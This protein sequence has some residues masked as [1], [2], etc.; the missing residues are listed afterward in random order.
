MTSEKLEEVLSNYIIKPSYY[1]GDYIPYMQTIFYNLIKDD[2]PPTQENY[3]SE[4]FKQVPKKSS[5]GTRLRSSYML[6]IRKYHL[7]YLLREEFENVIDEMDI[8]SGVDFI[9]NKEYSIHSFLKTDSLGFRKYKNAQ[10]FFLGKHI[11]L[12]L[13]LKKAKRVGNFLLYSK[14]DVIMLKQRLGKVGGMADA[15]E[16]FAS[17]NLAPST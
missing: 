9:V 2:I 4:F 15:L 5:W 6:F 13:D 14:E 8:I 16:Q 10:T 7:G 11:D 3:I 1:K 12:P 17:S